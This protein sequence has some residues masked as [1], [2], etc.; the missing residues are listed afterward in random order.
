MRTERKRVAIM[1][2]VKVRAARKRQHSQVR[3]R[4]GKRREIQYATPEWPKA[5]IPQSKVS[6][7]DWADPTR[8]HSR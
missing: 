6:P 5:Q 8:R 2:L 3:L 4:Q 7:S 1:A